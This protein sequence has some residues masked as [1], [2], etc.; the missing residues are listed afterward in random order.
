MLTDGAAHSLISGAGIPLGKCSHCQFIFD[1]GF[2]ELPSL[3]RASDM[4]SWWGIWPCGLSYINGFCWAWEML[5]H[6]AHSGGSRNANSQLWVFHRAGSFPLKQN[7]SE[8]TPLV[9][10]RRKYL[11]GGVHESHWEPKDVCVPCSIWYSQDHL[12][13]KYHLQKKS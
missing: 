2:P 7:I 1:L 6:Q 8:I 5:Q 13:S 9:R 3:W 12:V 11:K 10:S 4:G